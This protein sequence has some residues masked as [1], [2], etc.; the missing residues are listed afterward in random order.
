MTSEGN[1]NRRIPIAIGVLAIVVLAFAVY[2]PVLPGSFLMDDAR[3][4][5]HDNP[6]VTGQVTP[7]SIWFRTDFT[8][9]TFGW[10]VEHLTFD[11]NPLG[12]H[13]I[14]ITLH[15]LSALLL[16]RLL[17]RLKIPGAWLA[18]ALYAVHP[19]CV[20]SVARIAELKNTLSMPFFLLSF[21]AYLRY[22]AMALYPAEPANSQ[23]S[24]GKAT[25]A[26]ALWLTVSLVAFVLA[27]LAKTT[28]VML[29][30]V[31]LL[32]ALWQR[33]RIAW[34][35]VLHTSPL[36]ALSIAFGIMS[37]W[38]QKNQALPSIQLSLPPIHFPQ[39]L[40]GAG[41]DFW[42]YLGKALFP[43]NLC[44]VYPRWKIE[45]GSAMAFAPDL[46]ACGAFIVCLVFRRTWGWHLF[47]ALG[48]FVVML[49]P[50]LGFFDAQYL[51]MWDVSDHLQYSALAA[52]TALV[53]AALAAWL[54][55]EVF[56]WAAAILV[57]AC[58]A[59][60]FTHAEAFRTQESL[61]LDT[62]A[63]N[64]LSAGAHNDLGV[65]LI[66][67]GDFA[68]AAQEFQT[69]VECDPNS[70]DARV[71]FGHILSMAGKL[72]EAEAQF[73]AALKIEPYDPQ[74][75]EVYAGLLQQEGKTAA[76]L[77]H[78]RTALLF[79]PDFDTCMEAASLEYQ[80]GHSRRAVADFRQALT[81]KTDPETLNNLAWI[82]ATCPDESVRN[83]IDAI[84]Y[85]Q[86]ACQ[87]TAY[88]RPGMVGT[89]AAAYA[90]AGDFSNAVSTA[91]TA[92][93]LATDA[94]NTQ[95]AEQNQQLLQLYRAGKPYREK[96]ANGGQ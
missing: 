60:C 58:S 13:V 34:K 84:S 67:K 62:I 21:L 29:P 15:A 69:A 79:K 77:Y 30:V 90:D 35:D 68:K 2:S 74:A 95:F 48:A 86:W 96:P 41:Y 54:N 3:L 7:T 93:K 55:R 57:L 70:A 81:F 88:K 87:Q 25:R 49:F 44:I 51:T 40:A 28:V 64:P 71:N 1:Q 42:F 4:T 50:A 17:A 92:I 6:L 36:F 9:A 66:T 72:P 89:L 8:L 10:W 20:N 43:V 75:H 53:A 65:E 12:Y 27:L 76:A 82:L 18:G 78:L 33:R 46:L 73:Q 38:F 16:W 61:M 94:G 56:P 47:F 11:K 83:G 80:T 39:R 45:A 14:N 37:V 91:E 32:C 5:G 19:V 31:L 85:A 59:L 63:K 23:S 22:E 24:S 26:R 52:I